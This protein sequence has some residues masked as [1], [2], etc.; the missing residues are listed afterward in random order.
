VEEIGMTPSEL[1]SDF[2]FGPGDPRQGFLT[3]CLYSLY[4][5]DHVSELRD[6]TDFRQWLL[7]LALAARERGRE[8]V[9]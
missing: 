3:I 1:L 5:A 7:D 9:A 4:L 8:K 6:A 2:D